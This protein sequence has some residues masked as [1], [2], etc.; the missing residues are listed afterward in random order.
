MELQQYIQRIVKLQEELKEVKADIRQV[1]KEAK[2]QGHDTKAIKRVIKLL[3]MSKPD[4]DEFL[5]LV[6]EY[7]E[8]MTT[9][10]PK[11]NSNG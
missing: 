9:E 4:R 10:L 11:N 6:N 5:F 1:Y 3:N 7:L 8:K 2:G